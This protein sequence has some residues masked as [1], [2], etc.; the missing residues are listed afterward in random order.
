MLVAPSGKLTYSPGGEP[1]CDQCHRVTIGA[2]PQT[3][4]CDIYVTDVAAGA[5]SLSVEA[6][7][8]FSAGLGDWP[9]GTEGQRSVRST[10]AP[11]RTRHRATWEPGRQ[12]RTALH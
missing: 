9:L 4:P 1:T 12:E 8:V 7:A 10:M 6:R 5:L 3:Q 2:R 11:G